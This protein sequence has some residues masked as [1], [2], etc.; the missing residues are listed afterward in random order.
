[1][2]PMI[3]QIQSLPGLIRQVTPVYAENIRKTLSP[4]YCRSIQRIYLTGCGDSHH[5]ALGSEL[6]FELLAGI[7]TEAMTSLQFARYAA[8]SLHYP[9]SCLVIGT[10]VSGEVSRSVEG[11][12]LARKAGANTLAMTASPA[13]RIAGSA[14]HVM[15]T[16]QPPFSDPPGMVV[17]GMRS[18]VANQIAL[19]LTAIHF[20]E[21]TNR[22]T[23]EEAHSLRQEVLGLSIAAEKTIEMNIAVTHIL[24]ERW[25]DAGE[26][27]FCGGG[28]NYSSALFSSAKILEATG[29]SAL[30]QDLEEWAHLQYFAKN[31]DTP[32][33]IITAGDRDRSRAAEIIT[34]ADAIGRRVA[35]V[36]PA[37]AGLPI[38]ADGVL[39]PLAE[40]VREMFTPIISSIP[41]SLYAAH[42]AEI[43]AEPYF[44]DFKGGR[45]VE[46]G[47]G[48]S[49]IR[50]SEILGLEFL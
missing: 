38:P 32:T 1:M 37:S 45:S 43:I 30:G 48:I 9:E 46:G 28:P 35:V 18:Y 31:P 39:L 3:A 47:G 4:E 24:A 7:T 21:Q 41:A 23:M 25:V 36:T 40:P 5:A 20:G 22:L 33:F 13:S 14:G 26:Y 12:L 6:A 50:T 34:A 15:D 17:P 44:R 8:D 49:R 29:D 2:N 10:S 16:A 27:V 19:L 11:L 42:R